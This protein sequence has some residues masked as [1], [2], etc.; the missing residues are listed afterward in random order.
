MLGYFRSQKRADMANNPLEMS[1]VRK[2]LLLYLQGRSK[3]FISEYLSLSRNTVIKY[4]TQSKLLG[5]DESKLNS[6]SDLELDVMFSGKKT[7]QLTS[8]LQQLYDYFPAADRQLKKP[9]VTKIQLWQKYKEKHPDGVQSTQF[10]EHYARWSK[11]VNPVMRM[12][13][14]AGDKLYVLERPWR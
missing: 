2:V 3:L 5:I 1:K 10:F 8:R 9:G 6:L 4:I 14:K 12:T 7:L 13:H 11:K